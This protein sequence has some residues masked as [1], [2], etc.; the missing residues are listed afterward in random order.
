MTLTVA[1]ILISAR[2]IFDNLL[3]LSRL[4]NFCIPFYAALPEVHQ[5]VRI[6]SVGCLIL[7]SSFILSFSTGSVSIISLLPFLTMIGVASGFSSI[8]VEAS[9]FS[10]SPHEHPQVV[11]FSW[12]CFFSAS[13]YLFSAPH[14]SGA[15]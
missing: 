10:C 1:F 5:T 12:R 9:S 11:V 6:I 13:C 14:D 8:V 4:I 15:L 2:C 3:S 7:S